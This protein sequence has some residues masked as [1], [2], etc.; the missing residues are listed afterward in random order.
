MHALLLPS[1]SQQRTLQHAKLSQHHS[2]KNEKVIKCVVCVRVCYR[3]VIVSAICIAS[4]P[5]TSDWTARDFG[6]S[7]PASGAWP[8]WVT[9]PPP[10]TLCRL[11]VFRNQFCAFCLGVLG[12]TSI[13]RCVCVCM[14]V[15][16]LFPH[17]LKQEAYNRPVDL[18]CA[19][20]LDDM[21]CPW[22]PLPRTSS[23]EQTAKRAIPN[24]LIPNCA[25]MPALTK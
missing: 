19:V 13:T 22:L 8:H 2:N 16:S 12:P 25:R 10:Q 18:G 21:L 6:E 14:V 5:Q 20:Y 1:P 9:T 11:Y 3:M 7:L 17:Y 23:T 24:P 4:P 15:C